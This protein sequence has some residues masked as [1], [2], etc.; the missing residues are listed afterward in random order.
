MIDTENK[1]SLKESSF[2]MYEKTIEEMRA[3]GIDTAMVEK[4]YEDTKKAYECSGNAEF[5]T[6][7]K[8][9]TPKT[10][11]AYDE[12]KGDMI[13]LIGEHPDFSAVLMQNLFVVRFFD[14]PEY[15]IRRV[16]FEDDDIMR[17]GF[18]ESSGFCV[19]D[20]LKKNKK[21]LRGTFSIEY[22]DKT[23]ALLRIDTYELKSIKKLRQFPL[24]YGSNMP[25]YIEMELKYRNHGITTK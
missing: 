1:N 18:Y 9:Q 22:L 2:Q 11:K 4:E 8:T 17:I 6:C 20:Y 25:V 19:Y 13:E 14:I 5:N 23:G 16:F 10:C 7:K 12:Y 24:D 15:L 21:K 3:R